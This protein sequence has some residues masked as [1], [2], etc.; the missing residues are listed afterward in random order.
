MGRVVEEV[1]KSKI[2]E[3][4]K[5]IDDLVSDHKVIFKTISDNEKKIEDLEAKLYDAV[6]TSAKME[7]TVKTV[8]RLKESENSKLKKDE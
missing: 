1:H 5:R 8:L 6:L 4:N 2:E 7:A 3:L